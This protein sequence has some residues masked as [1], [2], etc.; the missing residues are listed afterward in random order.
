MADMATVGFGE[1]CETNVLYTVMPAVCQLLADID[2]KSRGFDRQQIYSPGI[3]A[4]L[5][6]KRRPGVYSVLFFY[7]Q[8]FSLTVSQ[9]FSPFILSN[10]V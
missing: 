8:P 1:L 5:I 7:F 2:G 10:P 3:L 4:M 6:N 9:D